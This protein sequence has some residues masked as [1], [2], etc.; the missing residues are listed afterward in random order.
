MSLEQQR[1]NLNQGKMSDAEFKSGLEWTSKQLTELLLQ[2][3]G[4]PNT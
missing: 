1:Q 2:T 3:S 4:D